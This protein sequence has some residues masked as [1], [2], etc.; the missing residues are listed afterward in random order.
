M[1][2]N[3]TGL[4]P[5][6]AIANALETAGPAQPLSQRD[7][8]MM[9]LRGLS[10]AGGRGAAPRQPAMEGRQPV[11]PEQLQ[12]MMQQIMAM[13]GAQTGANPQ[14]PQRGTPR[15]PSGPTV[16]G[17]SDAM[18]RFDPNNPRPSNPP[19]QLPMTFDPNNPPQTNIQPLGGQGGM[20]GI[21]AGLQ[22]LMQQRGQGAQAGAVPGVASDDVLA[23]RRAQRAQMQQAM[24]NLPRGR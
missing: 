6:Q 22:N 4:G 21:L 10:R 5:L 24:Q 11:S 15:Q 19:V 12:Q 7:A 16:G 14:A 17:I 23:R 2:A 13:R 1:F 20:A 18:L 9:T 8:M 3:S